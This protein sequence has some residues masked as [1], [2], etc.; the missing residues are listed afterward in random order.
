MFQLKLLFLLDD[1]VGQNRNNIVQMDI[2]RPTTKVDGLSESTGCL[3]TYSRR[4]NGWSNCIQVRQLISSWC[5][6]S[7]L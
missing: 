3:Y 5:E 6:N 7:T 2:E 4:P 1:D